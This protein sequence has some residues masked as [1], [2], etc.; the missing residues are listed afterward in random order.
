MPL[1]PQSTLAERL[2]NAGWK[3]SWKPSRKLP[4]KRS[5]KGN[6]YR[7]LD[8]GTIV[9]VFQYHNGPREGAFG[10]SL[11]TEEFGIQF[12]DGSWET[13]EE[14][15]DATMEDVEELLYL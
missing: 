9:T 7:R 10:Y 6:P 4:W 8:N 14:A 5:R 11:N 12:A 3:L 1:I 2:Q 13:E 15:K